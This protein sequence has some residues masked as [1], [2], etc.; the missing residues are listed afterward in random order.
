MIR[1][2]QR[3]PLLHQLERA[4]LEFDQQL[5]RALEISASKPDLSPEDRGFPD[6]YL[7]LALYRLN[8]VLTRLISL[9]DR[10]Y[11][12]FHEYKLAPRCKPEEVVP[13]RRLS[14]VV[15][16]ATQEASPG[17]VVGVGHFLKAVVS[18]SLDRSPSTYMGAAI[19]NTFSVETLLWGLG[20]NAWTSIDDAPEVRQLMEALAGRDPVQDHQYLLTVEKG[21]VVFRTGS[22]LGAYTMEGHNG[23]ETRLAVLPHLADNYTGFLPSEIL[24][25]EDLLN[26]PRVKEAE[27][28]DYFERHPRFFRMWQCQD[29]YPHVYLTRE[30]D[31][32]LIPDFLLVDPT[33]QKAVML[34]L[35]LPGKQIVIGGKNRRRL[36]APVMEARAQLLTY[37]DWFEDPHNRAKLKDRVGIEIFRPHLSVVIGRR[38]EFA[39]ELERQRIAAEHADLELVTYDDILEFAKRRL[40]LV[41]RACR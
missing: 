27:L 32:D 19:H 23:K 9:D 6:S 5:M 20:Y 18:L 2:N 29:V 34:D 24:E 22:V 17:K 14:A 4:G 1:F 21:R 13:G 15:E 36:A 28:Q 31:G 16:A 37:R 25:L 26:H 12:L 33:L 11:N 35:K 41:H 40:L 30:D 10:R 39:S 38:N 3:K 7:T 8:T